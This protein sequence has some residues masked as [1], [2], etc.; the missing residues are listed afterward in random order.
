MTNEVVVPRN[1][2]HGSP[3]T[4]SASAVET[5]KSR[6]NSSSSARPVADKAM[7]LRAYTVI[8]IAISIA[9]IAFDQRNLFSWIVPIES[10]FALLM[11]RATQ[12]ASLPSFRWQTIEL[13]E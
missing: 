3:Y 10:L 13:H 11:G 12:A 2:P 5:P 7:S 1:A 9:C 8:Y 6:F 4:R